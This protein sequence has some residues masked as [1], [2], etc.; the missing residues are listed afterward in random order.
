M[1]VWIAGTLAFLYVYVRQ[2][3]RAIV[4]LV[5]FVFI[6]ISVLAQGRIED[7]GNFARSL[8]PA[9][10]DWV[11][12]AHPAGDVVLVSSRRDATR[13]LETAFF[14]LSISRVRY[15]CDP[16]LGPEFGEKQVTIERSGRLRDPAGRLDGTVRRRA[17]TPRRARP[18]RRAQPKRARAPC[19]TGRRSG[20]SPARDARALEVQ[21]IQ[22]RRT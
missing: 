21:V 14:N 16:I 10:A 20:S 2:R 7:G 1:A 9:H 3:L 12:R 15:V 8:L 5:L 19:R 4:L 13:E 17:D 11:D 18:R 6:G 22:E